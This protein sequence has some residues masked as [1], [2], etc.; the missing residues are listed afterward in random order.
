MGNDECYFGGGDLVSDFVGGELGVGAPARPDGGSAYIW[1]G[2]EFESGRD[3][4]DG[5]TKFVNGP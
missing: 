4:R 2:V 1:R 5:A 3:V